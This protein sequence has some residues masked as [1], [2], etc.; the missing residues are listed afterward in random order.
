[1][2]RR[3]KSRQFFRNDDGNVIVPPS[4][5]HR[6]VIVP[7]SLSPSLPP[8]FIVLEALQGLH[9]GW[10]AMFISPR[11]KARSECV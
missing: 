9:F 1:M 5:C 7:P 11:Q 3:G 4:L 2:S 8:S 10:V 6:S